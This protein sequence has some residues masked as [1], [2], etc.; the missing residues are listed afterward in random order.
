MKK[1][2]G[3]VVSA[4]LAVVQPAYAQWQVPDHAVPVGRGTGVGFKFAV[5]GTAGFVLMSNG[6]GADPTFQT[7]PGSPGG[8][9][10]QVQYNNAGAFGGFTV[11]GDAT[12]NTGTGALALAT[13]NANVGSFGSSTLCTAITVNAKG[14]ITAASEATCAPAIG[15][16]TGLGTGV[17]T[18]L[19]VNIG[20]A[21]APVL[22]NGAGG[23]P[24]AITLTN[25]TGLPIAGITGLGTGVGAALA[26]NVGSAGAPVLFNGAGGTPASM[27]LTNATG[28]PLAGIANIGANTVLSNWT[29]GVR[30]RRR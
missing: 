22:F 25:G 2:F 18:A 15:S 1:L 19:G 17:A 24:S 29:S 21:G 23:T 20:S 30:I 5:P 10:G 14:L 6:A 3:F 7:N 26:V 11:S 28:L 27:T 9:N 16:I 4:F 8:T 13:V 12:L